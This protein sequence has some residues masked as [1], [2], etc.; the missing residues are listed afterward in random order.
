MLLKN[1]IV[2]SEFPNP[3]TNHR[4]IIDVIAINIF[5]NISLYLSMFFINDLSLFSFISF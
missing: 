1:V 4:Y 2:F 5:V 3:T